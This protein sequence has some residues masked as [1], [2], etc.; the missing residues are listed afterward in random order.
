MKTTLMALVIIILI[1]MVT[2]I[3]KDLHSKGTTLNPIRKAFWHG[4]S[5][6][7]LRSTWRKTYEYGIGILTFSVLDG[8][9]LGSTSIAFMCQNYSIAELSVTIAC[10]VEVYSVYENMEAVSGNNLFKKVINVFPQRA[11][12]IFGIKTPRRSRR[13]PEL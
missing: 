12:S 5:S 9:V 10:L 11:K 4:V 8:M 7:G 2:G 3:R 6:S 1:D 13:T